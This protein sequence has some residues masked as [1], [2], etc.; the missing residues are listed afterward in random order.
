MEQIQKGDFTDSMG[1][2]AKM[3]AAYHEARELLGWQ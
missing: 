2:P 1:N 3:L